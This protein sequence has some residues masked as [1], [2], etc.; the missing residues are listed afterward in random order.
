MVTEST[1]EPKKM[2]RSAAPVLPGRL[3]ASARTRPRTTKT[4]VVRKMN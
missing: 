4:G 2:A 1:D 3:S